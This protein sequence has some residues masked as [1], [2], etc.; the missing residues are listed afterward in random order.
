MKRIDLK[1]NFLSFFS[2]TVQLKYKEKF[3]V[4]YRKKLKNN[5]KNELHLTEK[6]FCGKNSKLT[7][8]PGNIKRI[9]PENEFFINFLQLYIELRR[10]SVERTKNQKRFQVPKPGVEPGFSI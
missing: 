8:F 5:F 2:Y 4:G 7:A 3:E 10:N 1:M 6:K 9:G